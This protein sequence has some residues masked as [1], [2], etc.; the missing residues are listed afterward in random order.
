MKLLVDVAKLE[1]DGIVH[2]YTRWFE[3]LRATPEMVIAAG[4]I[5]VAI[6]FAL[7]RF[8]QRQIAAQPW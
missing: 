7:W 2:F 3:R 4:V 8:N 1:A 5:A 6:A